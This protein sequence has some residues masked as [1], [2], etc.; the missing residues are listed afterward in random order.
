M[1]DGVRYSTATMKR[2]GKG[3]RTRRSLTG[4]RKGPIPSFHLRRR[5]GPPLGTEHLG[6]CL[7]THATIEKESR[8]R[9][10]F[11]S[12]PAHD[13][14]WM[15]SLSAKTSRADRQAR[16]ES[17]REHL[18]GESRDT[19]ASTAGLARDL[20]KPWTWKNR[21]VLDP[22]FS[23]TA[24]SRPLKG[25]RRK[26]GKVLSRPELLATRSHTGRWPRGFP[27]QLLAQCRTSLSRQPRNQG[28]L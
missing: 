17:R 20:D 22:A 4:D 13:L 10:A 7:P 25:L 19:E 3:A 5:L 23:I 1:P 18:S 21:L 14:L 12:P 15:I 24:Q 16:P 27:G 28:V 26:S 9:F 8:Q 11:F 6:E 2:H